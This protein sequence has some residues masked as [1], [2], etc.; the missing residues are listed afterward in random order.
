MLLNYI[1]EYICSPKI[2]LPVERIICNII[3]E[4]VVKN[5]WTTVFSPL[6]L[7]N[8]KSPIPNISIFNSHRI[9]NL[10]VIQNNLGDLHQKTFQGSQFGDHYPGF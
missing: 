9:P 1:Y 6:A 4:I 5:D 3:D 8:G 10:P 7:E 2:P